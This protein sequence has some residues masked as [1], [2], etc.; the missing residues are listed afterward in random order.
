[1]PANVRMGAPL[2]VIIANPTIW[3]LNFFCNLRN[4]L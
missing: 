3:N 2:G 1:M 4:D